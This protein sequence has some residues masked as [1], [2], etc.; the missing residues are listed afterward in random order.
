MKKLRHE[1][2]RKVARG[3]I[4]H[5]RDRARI[6]TQAAIDPR[7]FQLQG[8]SLWML[9]AFGRTANVY[10]SPESGMQGSKRAKSPK[11][12]NICIELNLEVSS[13]SLLQ[14]GGGYRRDSAEIPP[15]LGLPAAIVRV[16]I[17]VSGSLLGPS[18]FNPHDHC[19]AV[20]V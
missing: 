12:K 20:R 1:V 14:R 8:R 15:L 6:Q 7:S 13:V 3:H 19:F 9:D 4:H 16:A 5:L 18:T 11:P 10:N 17:Y 2:L